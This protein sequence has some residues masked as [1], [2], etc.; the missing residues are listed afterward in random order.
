[1]TSA[2]ASFDRRSPVAGPGARPQV[3]RKRPSRGDALSPAESRVLDLAIAGVPRRYLAAELG[4][5]ENTVKTQI[6]H[7]LA[8]LGE[9][10]LT[11]A[12]WHRRKNAAG[13]QEARHEA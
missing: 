13:R 8:K 12:A 3:G 5:A 6:R 10:N 1:V 4:V 2:R 9:K 7:L 11:E